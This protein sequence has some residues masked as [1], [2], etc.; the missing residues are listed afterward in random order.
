MS[1]SEARMVRCAQCKREYNAQRLRSCPGCAAVSITEMDELSTSSNQTS[2]EINQ[3]LLRKLQ[4]EQSR[5]KLELNQLYDLVYSPSTYAVVSLVCAFFFP[6]LAVIFGH[7]AKREIRE[8][9]GYKTGEGMANAGLILGYL[10]IVGI[11]LWIFAIMS[12][13]SDATQYGTY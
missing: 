8:S 3:Q 6:I 1:I 7:M 11:V 12:A 5:M 13:T 4:D 9:N 10:G 2:A